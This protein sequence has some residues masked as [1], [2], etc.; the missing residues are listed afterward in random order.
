MEN[1][2]EMLL[3]D[4][5]TATKAIDRKIEA[6]AI[7]QIII[8]LPSSPDKNDAVKDISVSESVPRT[9]DLKIPYIGSASISN[10]GV[11]SKSPKEEK[12]RKQSK[13]GSFLSKFGNDKG[14]SPLSLSKS[15]SKSLSSIMNDSKEK[16]PIPEKSLSD[17]SPT[18]KLSLK[19]ARS[20]SSLALSI[21]SIPESLQSSN[22]SAK[23][24]PIAFMPLKASESTKDLEIQTAK[25][26]DTELKT[27]KEAEL[28]PDKDDEL[29]SDKEAEPPLRIETKSESSNFAKIS[30]DFA[31][32][33]T[34]PPMSS[35]SDLSSTPRKL[36]FKSNESLIRKASSSDSLVS[37]T[38]KKERP[39]SVFMNNSSNSPENGSNQ[40]RADN[41]RL[42]QTFQKSEA[43]AG[44]FSWM[45]ALRD[46]RS[47]EDSP[48]AD[49]SVRMKA[50]KKASASGVFSAEETLTKMKME[51]LRSASSHECM[52][53]PVSDEVENNTDAFT[54]NISDSE[55]T[56][57]R[58]VPSGGLRKVSL[59]EATKGF[60]TRKTSIGKSVTPESS[61]GTFIPIKSPSPEKE[62]QPK[63]GN[64]RQSMMFS[65]ETV[66][67]RIAREQT[68]S[69]QSN[70][71]SPTEEK[72]KVNNRKSSMFSTESVKDRVAR[73]K[74]ALEQSK[75][76]SPVEEQSKVNN[77][78]SSMFSTES[79]KDRVARELAA[80]EKSIGMNLA[81]GKSKSSSN[82][83]TIISSESVHDAKD[84]TP[85][86]IKGSFI[87]G[88]PAKSPNKRQSAMLTTEESVMD[89]VKRLNSENV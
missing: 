25:D 9:E 17:Q 22:S 59:P 86:T 5:V 73:E 32:G 87:E 70:G 82:M 1:K 30:Q 53:S 38:P 19:F 35:M 44:D 29:K 40:R 36:A 58:I 55:I 37:S 46:A 3:D 57:T 81:Q 14:S 15:L 78:K 11:F 2:K 47:P 42:T 76:R 45:K 72:S 27:D 61:K 64:K 75:G 23:A 67:D 26:K 34:Y 43:T 89:R 68:A 71:K 56:P 80:S 20:T 48:P 66:K 77:R 18:K 31:L 69:E 10:G 24:R 41:K 13:I 51:K 39:R 52:L 60:A 8:P 84:I 85:E 21:P 12:Q 74:S 7:A 83:A 63:S 88:K 65:T 28:K 49:G 50:K 33:E 79:V 6:P 54:Y 4:S 62:I 16:L